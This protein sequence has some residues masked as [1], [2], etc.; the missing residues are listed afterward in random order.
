MDMMVKAEWRRVDLAER[1]REPGRWRLI[2]EQTE[3][4]DG[5]TKVGTS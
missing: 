5:E 2:Q 4:R 1:N 3:D